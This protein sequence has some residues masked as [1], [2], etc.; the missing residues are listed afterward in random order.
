VRWTVDGAS[1]TTGAEAVIVSS[2]TASSSMMTTET[3]VGHLLR[4]GIPQAAIR[5]VGDVMYDAALFFGAKAERESDVLARLGLSDRSYV[6]ATVHRAENT[7]DAA[8]LGAILAGLEALAQDVPV[9]LPLHP[10][11][12]QAVNSQ[13]LEPS[14]QGFHL[15]D[16]VG[17]LDMVRLERHA[18]AIATD[19]GGVQKEAFFYRVPCVTL[20]D[21]TEWTELVE[22]GWNRLIPPRAGTDLAGAIR[23]AIGSHGRDAQPYGDGNAAMRIGE[24]LLAS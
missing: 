16:P 9:I 3:A 13:G 2:G 22:L 24:A 15:L 19:S 12:R 11:T 8:R 4:E 17:Y 18:A 20:R 1:A 23:A 5:Q 6:L 21:E 7:D 10:R 14:A